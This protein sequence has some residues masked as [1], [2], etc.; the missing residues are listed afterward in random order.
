MTTSPA[1]HREIPV[2]EFRKIIGEE[3]ARTHYTG[4]RLIITKHGKPAAALISAKDLELLERIEMAEDVRQYDEAV[5]N[6]DGTR[7][8]MDDVTKELD[9]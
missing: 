9:A 6:D 2:A 5:A 3:I 8:T 7:F 1:Q 4:E